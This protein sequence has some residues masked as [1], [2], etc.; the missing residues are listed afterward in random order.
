MY[1]SICYLSTCNEE[2]AMD[3]VE[4]GVKRPKKTGHFVSKFVGVV[5]G[6]IVLWVVL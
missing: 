5:R 4:T 3:D 2:Q 1:Q 6:G